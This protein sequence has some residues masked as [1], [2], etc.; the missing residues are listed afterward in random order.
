MN[1]HSIKNSY[2]YFK[3]IE[4][5]VLCGKEIV[6][7]ERQYSPKPKDPADRIKIKE[8]ACQIHFM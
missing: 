1:I 3:T 8:F 7:K 6:Y 5:C 2:W 4:Y